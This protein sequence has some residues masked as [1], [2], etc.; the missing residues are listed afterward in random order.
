MDAVASPKIE[1]EKYDGEKRSREDLGPIGTRKSPSSTPVW[2]PLQP[3]SIKR[4]TPLHSQ[5]TKP[6]NFFYE[7]SHPNPSFSTPFVDYGARNAQHYNR[8]SPSMP[9]SGVSTAAQHQSWDSGAMLLSLL[10]RDNSDNIQLN[11][12]GSNQL[13]APM[14][15]SA[16]PNNTGWPQTSIRPPPGLT[17]L[18][19]PIP[20][21][22]DSRQQNLPQFDPFRSLGS[23]WTPETWNSASAA[24]ASSNT[25]TNTTASSDGNS[26][27]NIKN[28]NNVQQQ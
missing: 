2:E 27:L 7:Y 13:W 23:I 16:P 17:R 5:S 9:L 26:S 15:Y 22:N 3:A 12:W 4:P 25:Q 14:D 18:R 24:A 1:G 6:S 19:E 8:T 28:N 11:G 21:E 10:Q 20:E